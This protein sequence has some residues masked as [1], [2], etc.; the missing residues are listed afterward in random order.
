MYSNHLNDS[1]HEQF[2]V[3]I[4]QFEKYLNKSHVKNLSMYGLKYNYKNLIEK[5]GLDFCS[6]ISLSIM[7]VD[8]RMCMITKI[9]LSFSTH[10][11]ILVLHIT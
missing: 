4:L 6:I 10:L 3:H 5:N 11:Y 1:K 9:V 8:V 7:Q 2:D